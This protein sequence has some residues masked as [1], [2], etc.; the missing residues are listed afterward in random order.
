MDYK[1]KTKGAYDKYAEKF[2]QKFGEHFEFW[3]KKEADLFLENLEGMK[4]VDLGSGPGN[5]AA[6]FKENGCDVLCVDLSEEMMK[7]CR[8]KGLKAQAMDIE[9]LQL[10]EKSFD[11]VW[12]YASLLHILR[13][14]VPQVIKAIAKILKPG[15]MLGVAVKEGNREGFETNEKYPG[16]ERWFTY[17]TDEEMKQL[18]SDGFELVHS[19]K[20][21]VK[22]KYVFLN[23][24]FRRSTQ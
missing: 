19:S 2:D 1:N 20:T 3:V 7:I 17:F 23:Y 11:G 6:Y 16:T 13:E 10:P 12:A 18:F 5:H 24:F 22:N 8:Q 15:G 14:K 9:N 4:I 21:N